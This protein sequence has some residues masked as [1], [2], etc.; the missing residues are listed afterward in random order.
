M[1]KLLA[2]QLKRLLKYD[3]IAQVP[4]LLRPFILGVNEAYEHADSERSLLEQSLEIT[5]REFLE[6][7]E[8]LKH[9]IERRTKLEGE[10]NDFNHIVSHDLK[11]P[12]RSLVAFSKFLLDGYKDRLDEEGQ[13][14][15]ERIRANALR[16]H[17]LIEDLLQVSRLSRV[18]NEPVLVDLNHLVDEVKGRFEYTLSQRKVHLVIPVPLP[19]IMGDRVRLTEVFANLI[20]NAIKYNDKPECRI[21]ITCTPHDTEH[22][23]S[24]KDNGPGIEA[25]YFE[26]IFKIFERVGRAEDHEGTGVGLA[27]VKKVVELHKGRVW[28]E[29]ELGA[30]TTFHFTLSKDGP[31]LNRSPA[32]DEPPR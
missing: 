19:P 5:S 4:E 6:R 31:D 24:V 9:E 11:E 22:Q 27:I 20:S 30:A 14:Y 8:Q 26:K 16:M 12:L 28:V 2:R 3:D 1:H 23:I 29:S 13:V 32:T 25:K 18:P 17:E 21:E 7:Y 10:L 15:V